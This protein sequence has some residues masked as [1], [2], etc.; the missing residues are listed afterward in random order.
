VA[1]GR[2]D[3]VE[4]RSHTGDFALCCVRIPVDALSPTIEDL[5]ATLRHFPFVRLH[6]DAFLHIP[7]QELGFITD[8]SQARDEI[9]AQRLGEFIAQADLPI[10]DFPAFDVSL[11]GVNSFVDATFLDVH[12]D[13]WLSRIHRRLIDFVAIPPDQRFSYLPQVTIAHYTEA[14]PIGNLPAA[15]APWRDQAFGSFRV[16]SIDI[17]RLRTNE[18]YPDLV[19]EH[20]FQLGRQHALIDVMQGG[21]TA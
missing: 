8:R 6:P 13:G 10:S 2:H 20:Q 11:G 15:L 16:E 17:V 3:L 5:R 9:S 14:A 18:T 4:W 19:L 1:D 7:V 12:D 21:T